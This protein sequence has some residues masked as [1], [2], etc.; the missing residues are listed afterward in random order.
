VFLAPWLITLHWASP[1]RDSGAFIFANSV[2][3]LAGALYVGQTPSADT[4]LYALAALA[5]AMIGTIVGLV[6]ANCDPL[7]AGSNSRCS[8]DPTCGLVR[9]LSR[10]NLRHPVARYGVSNV[11]FRRNML[12]PG[13]RL[14]IRLDFANG[15]RIG[16]GKIALLEAIQAKGSITVAARHLGMSYRRAWLLIKEINDTVQQPVVASTQGGADGGGTVLTEVGEEVIKLYRSIEEVTHMSARQE[17][18]AIGRL[19]RLR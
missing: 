16:P 9:P 10:L 2:V 18:L 14:S 12:M 11:V 15:D 3:G 17:C 4:R 19:V 7:H 1:K 13:T 6:V 5:G 8:R